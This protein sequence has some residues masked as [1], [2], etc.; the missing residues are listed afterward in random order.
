MS[1]LLPYYYSR[2]FCR[3]NIV[4]Q[5]RSDVIESMT[6]SIG[7]EWENSRC[8][9]FVSGYVF[10][11]IVGHVHYLNKYDVVLYLLTIS[12]NTYNLSCEFKK[13][14]DQFFDGI[15]VMVVNPGFVGGCPGHP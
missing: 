6:S 11:Y 12:A 7:S 1:K 8:V 9:V 4:L 2:N 15:T 14:L 13:S 5:N 10:V 3:L